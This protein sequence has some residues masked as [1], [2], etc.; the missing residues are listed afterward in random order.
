[1]VTLPS[2][3]H[4]F[5][6]SK[7]LNWFFHISG[8]RLSIHS[9]YTQKQKYTISFLVFFYRL[10]KNSSRTDIMNDDQNSYAF[11]PTYGYGSTYFH[12]HMISVVLFFYS[13]T[14]QSMLVD[15]KITE[16]GC[17]DD[18]SDAE[19]RAKTMR[20]N[21][22]NT[23]LLHIFQCITFNQTY[24]YSNTYCQGIVEVVIFNVRFQGY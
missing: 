1:M 11:A 22:I 24:F 16:M 13:N 17:F 14:L 18:C 21:G 7:A 20:G 3:T 23:F 19:P 12:R 9:W 2:L 5:N 8:R 15:Y 4:I 6:S 10:K